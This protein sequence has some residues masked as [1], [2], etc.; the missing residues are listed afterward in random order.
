MLNWNTK[1]IFLALSLLLISFAHTANAQVNINALSTTELQK[2]DSVFVALTPEMNQRLLD[3]INKERISFNP[4]NDVLASYLGIDYSISSNRNSQ[5]NPSY[6]LSSY[7]HDKSN[8]DESD[9]VIYT[10]KIK[11][12]SLTP[13]QSNSLVTLYSLDDGHTWFFRI[14]DEYVPGE[15][16]T[17]WLLISSAIVANLIEAEE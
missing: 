11:V 3:L 5:T 14:S 8:P 10:H 15:E 7:T 13:N 2:Y 17:K 12:S 1:N 16:E 9:K 6:I 4:E